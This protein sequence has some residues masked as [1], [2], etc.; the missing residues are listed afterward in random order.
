MAS[1]VLA[2]RKILIIKSRHLVANATRRKQFH[3]QP[4]HS[5]AKRFLAFAKSR[6][7]YASLPDGKAFNQMRGLQR[8][9]RKQSLSLAS[10]SSRRQ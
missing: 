7:D 4:R 9:A 5:R 6:C 10:S 2:A 3:I 8:L 1:A